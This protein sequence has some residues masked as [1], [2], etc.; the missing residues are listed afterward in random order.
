ARSFRSAS[1]A[2]AVED[3]PWRP[4]APRGGA[5]SELRA[6]SA[7]LGR[8]ERSRAKRKGHVWSPM[9][10][11]FEAAR[12]ADEAARAKA[13]VPKEAKEKSTK[14]NVSSERQGQVA[15]HEIRSQLQALAESKLRAVENEDFELAEKLKHQ[16]QELQ[17]LCPTKSWA[18]LVVDRIPPPAAQRGSRG[19][20]TVFRRG[21]GMV[22]KAGP[23]PRG[24]P[25]APPPVSGSAG[26]CAGGCAAA[27]SATRQAAGKLVFVLTAP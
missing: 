18:S 11:A 19:E 24:A 20:N 27:M 2:P 14:P 13:D 12:K 21:V 5:T 10:D 7:E 22:P 3:A 9:T 8:Q 17:Q 1:A 6:Q 25:A 26:G 15:Q 23:A 16:E 4:S